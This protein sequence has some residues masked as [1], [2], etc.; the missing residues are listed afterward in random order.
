MPRSSTRD[1]T[2]LAAG[3]DVFGV[4]VFAAL[5]HRNHDRSGTFVSVLE[6]AAPFLFGLATGWLVAR[7]WRRPAR[8][9]T[10][11]VIWPVTVLIGMIVRNVAFDRGTATSFVIVATVFVG[12][13]LI[14]W[15]A[16]VGWRERVS[17]MR[18]P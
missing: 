17:R 14:G 11:L 1:R 12:A 15:R 18:P 5:G 4:V 7:A 2:A 3:L 10:G 13:F 8:L 16:V 9:L 6:T